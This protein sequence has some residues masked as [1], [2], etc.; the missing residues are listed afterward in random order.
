MP[1]KTVDHSGGGHERAGNVGCERIIVGDSTNPGNLT[2][3]LT[4]LL[5]AKKNGPELSGELA[6]K[7]GEETLSKYDS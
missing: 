3:Q 2:L 1:E 7:L 5:E 4:D 6:Q